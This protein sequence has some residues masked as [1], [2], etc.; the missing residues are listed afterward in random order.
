MSLR[1]RVLVS[2]VALC[3]VLPSGCMQ[4]VVGRNPAVFDHLNEIPDLRGAAPSSPYHPQT[5]PPVVTPT[6]QAKT[7]PQP[8]S[9]EPPSLVGREAP[10]KEITPALPDLP[11]LPTTTSVAR[12]V[13]ELPEEPIVQ[14]LRCYLLNHPRERRTL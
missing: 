7:E 1:N 11:S 8:P 2:A 5:T 14:A 13:P 4:A 6:A 3:A 12:S 9:T 10:A